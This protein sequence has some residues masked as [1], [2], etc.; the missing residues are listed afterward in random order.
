MRKITSV[1]HILMHDRNEKIYMDMCNF[2]ITRA[3]RGGFLEP[4][5]VSLNFRL[6]ESSVVGKGLLQILE[7][8]IWT[9][10][11]IEGTILNIGSVRDCSRDLEKVF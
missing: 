5:W 2:P 11:V 4:A 7:Q 10:E 1:T 3:K 9:L 8:G 6:C